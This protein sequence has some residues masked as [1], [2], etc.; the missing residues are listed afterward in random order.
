MATTLTVEMM[1]DGPEETEITSTA[2]IVDIGQDTNGKTL[3]SVVLVPAAGPGIIATKGRG[4]ASLPIF[5]RALREALTTHGEVHQAE[6]GSLPVRAV[7]QEE[8]RKRFARWYADGETDADKSEVAARRAF[9]RCLQK[10]QA[11]GAI[12][13]DVDRKRRA[14]LWFAA[15]VAQ[16]T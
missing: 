8:V 16:A 14:V 3:T 10:A 9:F 6:V 15:S 7:L 5:Y 11:A 13:K 2:E 1:R 4:D 12:L